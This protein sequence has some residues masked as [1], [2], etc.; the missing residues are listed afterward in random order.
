MRPI[1]E[2]EITG[3]DDEETEAPHIDLIEPETDI[4]PILADAETLPELV[5]RQDIPNVKQEKYM[6]I[7]K[8]DVNLEALEQI[9]DQA[10]PWLA[11]G[12][13]PVTTLTANIA[14]PEETP[15]VCISSRVIFQTNTY[16]IPIM[17]GKKYETV[18][19]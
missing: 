4:D 7:E 17:S 2:L 18:K 1:G 10:V 13:L 19:T 6:G 14:T 15:G 8:E 5:E 12:E 9:I 3:V 11:E 16:H